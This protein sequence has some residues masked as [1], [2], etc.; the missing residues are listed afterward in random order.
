MAIKIGTVSSV[1]RPRNWREE[2]DDRQELVE[3]VGGVIVEDYGRVANG[4]KLS[5]TA[6]FTV[7]DAN[8]V[9]GYCDGRTIVNVKG[10]D[11][12]VYT[13]CGFSSIRLPKVSTMG[14]GQFAHNEHIR[15]V[16]E[17]AL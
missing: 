3:T 9:I 7:A 17:S 5:C 1:G 11:G 10:Q 14:V 13:G 2:P 15:D 8:T 16:S 4:D 6:D 12:T